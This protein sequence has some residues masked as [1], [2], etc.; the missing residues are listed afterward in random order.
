MRRGNGCQEESKHRN[1]VP[2]VARDR[3]SLGISASDRIVMPEIIVVQ[4]GFMIVV[5]PWEA[6]VVRNRRDSLINC[7][8]AERFIVG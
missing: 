6:E 3:V 5:L 4:S 1:N 2:L 8:F 7:C